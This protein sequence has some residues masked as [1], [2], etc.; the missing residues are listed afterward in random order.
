MKVQKYI[1]LFKV[2]KSLS[3]DD[4]VTI[5]KH[6]SEEGKESIYTLIH[7][8]LKTKS[9]DWSKSNSVVKKLSP[10]KKSLRYLSKRSNSS[11]TKT[12]VLT[13]Q[14]G[15]F[16]L[17]LLLNVALPLLGSVFGSAVAK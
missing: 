4:R 8:V 7:S 16:P 2:L 3:P 1:P 9:K 17:G 6:L 12:K 14:V 5:L 15:G 13:N 11:K 10:F